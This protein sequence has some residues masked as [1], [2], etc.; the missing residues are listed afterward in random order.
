MYL[1][2]LSIQESKLAY[3]DMYEKILT[4]AKRNT[5]RKSFD[6]GGG[7]GGLCI[8]MAGN[9]IE[10]EYVDIPGNTWDYTGFRFA[11]KGLD[12]RQRTSE[13]IRESD[14]TYDLITATDNLE[15]LKDLPEWI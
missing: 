9:G 2:E 12:I 1:L 7:I 15:H 11:K 8:Y 3:A 6:F 5:L 14:T 10:S 4:F 13:Q